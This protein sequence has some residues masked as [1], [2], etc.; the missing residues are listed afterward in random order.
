M[1]YFLII[2]LLSGCYGPS[3]ASFFRPGGRVMSYM[4]TGGSAAYNKGWQD[5]CNS[6]MSIYG[7][8]FHKD[9]YA[10]TKDIRFLGHQYGD[11]RDLFN[12]KPI[13]AQDKTDYQAAWG[14]AYFGCRH[15]IL[16]QQKG[17]EGMMPSNPGDRKFMKMEGIDQIYELSAWGGNT[18]QNDG[19]IANW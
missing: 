18:M 4:P 6:G 1:R 11:S 7:H 3:S 12:G 16:G 13:S 10:F 14:T 17:G 5:G 2:L 15:Y 19:N 8:E 9:F